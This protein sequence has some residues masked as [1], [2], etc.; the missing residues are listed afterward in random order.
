MNKNNSVA[1]TIIV[2]IILIVGIYLAL[3]KPAVDTI[4][5]DTT[6]T[7]VVQNPEPTPTP[8]TKT[9]TDT[10]NT[11]SFTYPAALT[12]T[13]GD[14]A[15]PWRTNT[16]VAGKQLATVTIPGSSQPNTNFS[17]ATFTVG[18][19]SNAAAVKNCTT[20]QNGERA[21]GTAVIDGV[22]YTKITLTDAGA[23]NYYDTT[24]YRNVHNSQC[25]AVEY[26]IHST[27]FANYP[28]GTITEFDTQK[29]VADLESMAQ[30][31]SFAPSANPQTS[32]EGTWTGPEGTSL[33]ISK[34]G[35]AYML[36][37]VMLDGPIKS[38]GTESTTG[39]TFTRSGKTFT[40][41]HGTGAET[42]MKYL[43]DKKNC[44][45]IKAA[46]QPAE[47]YCKD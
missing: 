43:V 40:L 8:T 26:T 30:S 3:K 42:G 34:T 36:N 39:I 23:G 32:F 22:T 47:G 29:V 41:T 46:G 25:Y 9:F 17:E 16:T 1:T 20:P 10:S 37:F 13:N 15:K 14:S 33:A 31:F 35:A 2:L 12:A 5:D 44:V 4:P 18:S 6:N 24:N 19:S 45:V 7:P 28:A 38:T 27:N 21:K 11:F